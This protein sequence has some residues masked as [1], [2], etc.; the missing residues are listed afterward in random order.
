MACGIPVITT[1][2]GIADEVVRHGENGLLIGAADFASLRAALD[3]LLGDQALSERYGRAASAAVGEAFGVE[4]V[5]GQYLELF[6]CVLE[7]YPR[8]DQY[9]AVA[10]RASDKRASDAT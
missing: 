3:V 2:V 7:G 5:T 4:A 1:P 8:A 6:K 9:P 10:L